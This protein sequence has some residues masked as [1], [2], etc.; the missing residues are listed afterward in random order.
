MGFA[1]QD[2]PSPASDAVPWAGWRMITRDYFKTLGVRIVAGRDF[3][4]QD[5]IGIPGPSVPREKLASAVAE[6]VR[7]GV[8]AFVCSTDRQ[9]YL[10]RKELEAHKLKVPQN[11]S[12]IG[13]GGV[14]PMEG[15]PQLTMYRTPYET[16]GVAAITRLRERRARPDSSAV[17]NEYPGSFIEGTSVGPPRSTR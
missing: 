13:F 14:T 8:T 11:L 9:A 7:D 17:F 15:Q 10:L 2:K 1:A 6:R 16:L 5:V 4:E 12:I 3:T